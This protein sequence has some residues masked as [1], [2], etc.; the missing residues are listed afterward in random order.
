MKAKVY[1][2][3]IYGRMSKVSAIEAIRK[4]TVTPASSVECKLQVHRQGV[5]NVFTVRL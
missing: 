2:C 3:N 4:C 5:N 1:A